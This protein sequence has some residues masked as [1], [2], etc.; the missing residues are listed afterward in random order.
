[1]NKEI[2][3]A[4]KI[5]SEKDAT[6]IIAE[7]SANHLMDYDRAVK[8]MLQAKEAGAD[9]VKLQTY[10][11]DTIT[12]NCDKSEFLAS[13]GSPWEGMNLYELYKTAYT[14]WEWQPKLMELARKMNIICFSSPFDFTAVDFMEDMNMPAYKIASFEINDIPLI[15]KIAKKK[16]PII[17][18]T[19]IAYM[20]EIEEALTVCKDEGNEDVILLKCTSA[21]PAPYEDI[22]LNTIP[23]MKE[24]FGC[25]TGLSDHTLGDSVAVASVALGAKVVEKHLTLK[26][27]DGGPDSTFSMEPK[28]FKNMVERIRTVE[29]AMGKVTYE[30]TE[31]QKNSRGRSRSLYV[32]EDV[33]K[34]QV[35]TNKNI[36]SIRPA[37]GLHTRYYDNIL[38]KTAKF[39]IEK[40]TALQW[41]H[42][43]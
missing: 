41:K 35:F 10:T 18:S 4:N 43:E 19:G 37:Y 17:I 27:E 13:K 2:C 26:R 42:I 34:G 25:I 15:R 9:A 24:T 28:E 5:I 30:L 14:P 33:K 12:L 22:N 36:R 40:G 20:K 11:P 3:I 8:I 31:K 6:F 32:V 1:M 16:K 7:I 39:N 38:G 29:K 23:N 21:Y